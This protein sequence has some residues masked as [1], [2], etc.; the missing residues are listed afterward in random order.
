[1]ARDIRVPSVLSTNYQRGDIMSKN[2]VLDGPTHELDFKVRSQ[3]YLVACSA[4]MLSDKEHLG[5]LDEHADFIR[6]DSEKSE[7]KEVNIRLYTEQGASE[8]GI[9][10]VKNSLLNTLDNVYITHIKN[11]HP[12]EM[13]EIID[14]CNGINN[15]V[16]FDKE[17]SKE[18]MEK[19]AAKHLPQN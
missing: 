17:Q 5:K 3:T 15:T 12:K 13:T 18:Q 1:M 2:I 8:D 7:L 10:Q 4:Y 16:S 19:E 9:N 11:V 14:F 6:E